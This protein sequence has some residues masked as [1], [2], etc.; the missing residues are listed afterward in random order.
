MSLLAVRVYTAF[1]LPTKRWELHLQL[2]NHEV[3][4]VAASGMVGASHGKDVI[5]QPADEYGHLVGQ[6]DRPILFLTQ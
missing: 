1:R 6:G 3:E 4:Q 5:P 2:G